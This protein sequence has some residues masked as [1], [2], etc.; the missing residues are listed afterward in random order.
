VSQSPL[1]LLMERPTKTTN[2]GTRLHGLRK[3]PS[4]RIKGC[5]SDHFTFFWSAERTSTVGQIRKIT[6]GRAPSLARLGTFKQRPTSQ[7]STQGRNDNMR[8]HGGKKYPNQRI[9]GALGQCSLQRRYAW[10]LPLERRWALPH[11]HHWPCS[12]L[13]K[14]KR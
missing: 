2:G 6:T 1:Y 13:S 12:H 7:T 10:S 5:T 3:R 8:E 4:Q 14:P 9:T 11:G